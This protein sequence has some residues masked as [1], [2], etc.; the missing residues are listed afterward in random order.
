MKVA[1]PGRVSARHTMRRILAGPGPYY[2][3]NTYM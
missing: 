2:S 3:I 1:V